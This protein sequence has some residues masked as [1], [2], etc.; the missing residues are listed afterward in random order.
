MT[1]IHQKDKAWYEQ[2]GNYHTANSKLGLEAEHFR[3]N[4][5]L[6]ARFIY[7]NQDQNVE[8]Y[9][10]IISNGEFLS[11]NAKEVLVKATIKDEKIDKIDFNIL[12]EKI[13][14]N[15]SLKGL[16]ALK[17]YPEVIGFQD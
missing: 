4:S 16:H 13:T 11:K 7:E 3:K 8:T 6:V 9:R 10:G 5:G 14:Q 2:N 17:F 15:E 1:A 12:E